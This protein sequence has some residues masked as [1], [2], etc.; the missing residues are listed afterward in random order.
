METALQIRNLCKSY[1][2]AD[3]RLDNISFQIL[4]GAIMGFVGK[5]CTGNSNHT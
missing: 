2:N 5:N 4:Q 3:F 1:K